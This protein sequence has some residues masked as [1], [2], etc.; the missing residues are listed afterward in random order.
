MWAI[1]VDDE[2]KDPGLNRSMEAS[3]LCH[4]QHHRHGITTDPWVTMYLNRAV[5]GMNIDSSD[6]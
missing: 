2:M 5:W 1:L 3:L 6:A 4:S